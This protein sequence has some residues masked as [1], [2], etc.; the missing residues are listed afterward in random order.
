[1]KIHEAGEEHIF[2]IQS[3]SDQIWPATFGDILST[4]QIAFMMEM[5]YSTASLQKQMRELGHHYLLVE[6]EGEYLGYLSYEHNYKNKSITKIHKIYVLPSLQ[7]KGLGRF[8]IDSVSSIAKDKGNEVL[9]LNVNRYNKALAFYKRLGFEIDGTE[10]ID[11]GQG[12]LME[13]YMLSKKL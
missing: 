8:F 7:G 1:M 13:D 6:D 5:M 9:T 11:I 2:I 4:E 12:F 10:D 3:L